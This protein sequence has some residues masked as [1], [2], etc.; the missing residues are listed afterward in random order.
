MSSDAP[1]APE[2][3][4][5]GSKRRLSNKQ[6]I[7][8]VVSLAVVILIFVGVLPKIADYGE[9]WATIRAMTWL[10]IATLLIAGAWNLLSYL[11]ILTSVLP[12]LTLRQAFV[13]T[14]ATTAVANTVPAGGAV[15]VGLTY[16]MYSSWG[17]T[18]AQTVLSVIVSGVWNN[19]VKLGMPVIAI[20]LLAIRGQTATGL[21][22]AAVVGV[23]VLLVAVVLFTLMLKSEPLARRIGSW[24]GRVAAATLRLARKEFTRDL[25]EAAVRFRAQTI[26]LLHRRWLVLT[27]ATIVSHVSL[28]LVL[29]I[30]LRHVGI[31]EQELGWVEVLASF[32]FVRL[33]SA[34]PITPGG[35]AVVELGYVGSFSIWLDPSLRA[36]AVAAVLVFRALT[37]LLPIPLGIGTYLFWRRNRSWRK[38]PPE[39]APVGTRPGAAAPT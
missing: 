19:F 14:Q 28:Y 8:I 10:E 21:V 38:Q 33:I 26:G 23:G 16:S 39:S 11:P 36:E 2:V 29:L 32:S 3:K 31:S 6:I 24:S 25:G 13:S 12:G 7:Q 27:I 35:L 15:A 30:T 9:V 20:A 5:S 4:R 37:Y 17:F 34:L 1:Q 18:G 22:L